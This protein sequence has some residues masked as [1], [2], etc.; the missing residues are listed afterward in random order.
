MLLVIVAATGAA[1]AT[2][3]IA[4]DGDKGWCGRCCAGCRRRYA[5]RERGYGRVLIEQLSELYFGTE[6]LVH[7][8]RR[9]RES[10]GIESELDKRNRWIK[11]L[12]LQSGQ[13]GE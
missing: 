8:V 2:V 1:I 6:P 10:E 4:A 9:L 3:V 7:C 5:V 11:A 12:G 13:I